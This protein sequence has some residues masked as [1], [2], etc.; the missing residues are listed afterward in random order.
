MTKNLTTSLLLVL[1]SVASH[2]EIIDFN[3][4]AVSNNVRNLTA[5]NY[6]VSYRP[7]NYNEDLAFVLD[8]GASSC[9]PACPQNGSNYI[10][11]WGGS[12]SLY[13]LDGAS[14]DLIGFDAAEAHIFYENL[15]SGSITVT[16]TRT[17]GTQASRS[18][19]LDFINDGDGPLE[20]FQN[21]ST[22]GIFKD[23]VSVTIEGNGGVTDNFFSIDNINAVRHVQMVPEPS[24]MILVAIGIILCWTTTRQKPQMQIIET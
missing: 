19:T 18:Y 7:Y 14:F 2:A 20:D 13:R 3:E 23:I 15:W 5:G 6:N 8:G 17:D 24:S 22:Q 1:A 16:G 11:T 21:F 9:N 4:F 10:F 12:W